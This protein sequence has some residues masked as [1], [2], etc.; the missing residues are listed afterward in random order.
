MNRSNSLTE[1]LHALDVARA[2]A[3]FGMMLIHV[4][5][6][7]APIS[8]DNSDFLGLFDWFSGRPAALFMV[9]AGVGVSLRARHANTVG[10]TNNISKQLSKRGL[11]FFVVGFMN[12]LL[13]PGD[14]LRVYGIA[15]LLAAIVIDWKARWLWFLAFGVVVEFLVLNGFIDFETNWDFNSLEYH[16]L[17]TLQ[18][19]L[20]NLFFNGFRAVLPWVSLFFLGMIMGR[21]ELTNRIVCWRWLIAGL[22]V[23]AATELL[24]YGLLNMVLPGT[25]GEERDVIIA[26]F[27]TLSLPPMPLFILASGGFAVAFIMACLLLIP[28]LPK[29]IISPFISVGRMAFTWYIAHIAMIFLIAAI[30]YPVENM[31]LRSALN[32]WLFVSALVIVISLITLRFA[33]RGPLEMLLRRFG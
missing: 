27:G 13:W 15:F 29:L 20:L 2:F 19:G 28:A 22:C 32:T 3:I 10:N 17:W 23:A 4:V 9:L 14:I 31:S 12:L 26:V 30:V 33:K 7:L 6:V 8:I 11:F 21:A 18:G 5:M 24:S 16:N 1:R 25:T